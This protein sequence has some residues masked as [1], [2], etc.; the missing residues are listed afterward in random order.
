MATL[1]CERIKKIKGSP[2]SVKPSVKLRALCV[3]VVKKIEGFTTETQRARSF[4]E[5]FGLFK[6][7]VYNYFFR[8][9]MRLTG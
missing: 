9:W 2:V 4:T 3:S 7:E 8:S 1:H 6:V 5:R